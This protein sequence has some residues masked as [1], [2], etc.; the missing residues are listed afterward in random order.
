VERRKKNL[1]PMALM[2]LVFAAVF[3]VTIWPEVSSAAKIAFFCTGF[4]C[5]VTTGA[6]LAVRRGPERES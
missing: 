6:F 5:G 2:F 1:V 3:S 4:G